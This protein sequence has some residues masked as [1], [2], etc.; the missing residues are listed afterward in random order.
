MQL[1][2]FRMCFQLTHQ[3]DT[4]AV[5]WGLALLA[6][7]DERASQVFTGFCSIYLILQIDT[8][9]ARQGESTAAIR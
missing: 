6:G 1:H 5:V 4:L 8:K 9:V 7:Q 2:T 3:L